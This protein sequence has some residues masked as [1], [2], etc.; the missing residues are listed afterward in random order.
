MYPVRIALRA[1]HKAHR[2]LPWDWK[3]ARRLQRRDAL[4]FEDLLPGINRQSCEDDFG[5]SDVHQLDVIL[6]AK[7]VAI[8]V[9]ETIAV[10]YVPSFVKSSLSSLTWCTALCGRERAA[11]LRFYPDL[12]PRRARPTCSERTSWSAAAA[13]VAPLIL[14]VRG[15]AACRRR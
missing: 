6:A 4:C 2:L 7:W 8:R 12:R 13:A 3:Y 5:R 1:A 10:R 14:P 9:D 15:Y 11:P